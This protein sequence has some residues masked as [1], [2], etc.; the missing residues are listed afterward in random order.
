MN[1]MPIEKIRGT[2]SIAQRIVNAENAFIE[3]LVN[4][5]SVTKAEA[6]RAMHTMLKLKVAK[7][8]AVSGE[9]RVKHGAYLEADVIRR[10]ATL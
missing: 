7:M 8:D 6:V 10:A 3:V 2:K 5:G 9:I 1:N 4:L